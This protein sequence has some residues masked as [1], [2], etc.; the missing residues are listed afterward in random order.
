MN[1]I[2]LVRAEDIDGIV[3]ELVGL[4]PDQRR[5]FLPELKVIRKE[6]RDAEWPAPDGKPVLIAGLGCHT[7]PS[8]AADWIGGPGLGW[9]EVSRHPALL[10]VIESQP[11]EWQHDVIARLAERRPGRWWGEYRL[12]EH[13]VRTTGCPVPTSDEFVLSWVHERSAKHYDLPAHLTGRMPGDNLWDRLS[14]D[15]FVPLLVPRLFE[16]ADIGTSLDRSWY[17]TEPGGGWPVCLA[18]LT[19]QGVLDRAEM[20]D[21]CL[22]RLVRGGRVGDQRVFLKVL[23]A[24]APSTDENA[25]RVR[26]YLAL[27][28]AVSTVAVHAQQVLGELDDAGLLAADL[29][30]EASG[31]VLFRTEKKLV[32][33][34][35]VRL[36]KAAGRD[37]ALAGQV[38]LA[39]SEAFGHPDPEVQEHTL[40]L[41][42]RH[43]AAAGEGVLPRL[44]EAAEALHPAHT[45]SAGELLGAQ[46]PSG[47]YEEL[48][49]PVPQPAPVPGPLGSPAEVAE[50]LS[51]ILLGDPDVVAFERALD[52][53]VRQAHLSRPA[54]TEALLPVLAGH[55]H[56]RRDWEDCTARDLLYVARA[57]TS[58]YAPTGALRSRDHT[59]P[60]GHQLAGRLEEAA[61]L[62]IARR[63][64][65]L[66]ATPTSGTG[67]LDAAVLVERLAGYEAVDAKDGDADLSQ[68]LLRVVPTDDP[69]VL[70]AAE[71]LTST[72]G[73]RTARWLK[74]GGLPTRLSGPG[75]LGTAAEPGLAP[76]EV[77]R[78]LDAVSQQVEQSLAVPDEPLAAD[79]RWLLQPQAPA[80]R[81]YV[82]RSPESA[83]W[84]S[85]FPNH[86]E[87]L[88]AKMLT[89]SGGVA[90]PEVKGCTRLLPHLAEAAGPAGPAVHLAVGYGLGA[91]L[92]E[93]RLAAVDG[94]LVLAARGDLDGALLGGM[95]AD[96]ASCGL[97]EPARLAKSFRTAADT[98]A[99]GTVWSVLAGA[100]PGL[101]SRTSARG[102]GELLGVA[103]DCAQRSGARGA[104][105]KVSEAAGRGGAN[106]VVK[107]AKALR[108]VL[109]TGD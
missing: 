61:R 71:H 19:E 87:L 77:I 48:L 51:A 54:L 70:A 47:T 65:Y 58:G 67:A 93:D 11:L 90:N 62:I 1:L 92:P 102:L 13:L 72:A 107:Q 20:L 36:D 108:E 40:K 46:L 95:L 35:L 53:L 16:I 103:V 79:C 66:L 29:L 69:D 37:P 109:A 64:P 2:E 84:L 98:G 82:S 55:N 52:G 59:S 56:A 3:R 83:H 32:R 44:R 94:L 17:V 23:Q 78:R 26:S 105:A 41:I 88:A 100:L 106:Q 57:A 28:D 85:V 38:V 7:S 80:A 75:Y 33:T 63:T 68:A 45:A 4:T 10:A 42:A 18:R 43:L 86:R 99:Y 91:R 96:M 60:F 14:G 9:S 31:T 22:A 50:E 89:W 104:I 39:A 21:G 97:A 24:L 25:A 76:W 6:I 73:Q 34:Q 15:S 8:G 30:V 101:L 81:T 27:L 5:A 12:L 74:A 49:P